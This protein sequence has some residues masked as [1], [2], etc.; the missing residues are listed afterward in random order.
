MTEGKLKFDR[1]LQQS[2]CLVLE[3]FEN[4]PYDMCAFFWSLTTEEEYTVYGI[5]FGRKVLQ[6]S[7]M[8]F[9]SLSF[10]LFMTIL[11]NKKKT[12]KNAT[13]FNA[14]LQLEP[15]CHQRKCL[16]MKCYRLW[17]LQGLFNSKRTHEE[18]LFWHRTIRHYSQWIISSTKGLQER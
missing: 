12:A 17:Y 16:Q 6:E 10:A 2:S 14:S 15:R 9:Q 13:N 7:C 1:F 8:I 4:S 3:D 18:T 5:H 11:V